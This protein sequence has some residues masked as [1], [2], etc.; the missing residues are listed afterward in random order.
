MTSLTQAFTRAPVRNRY[1]WGKLLDAEHLELEQRYHNEKR[2]LINRHAHGTGVLCGLSVE[3][4]DG[5]R[6]WIRPGVALDGRGREIVVTESF[7]L[8]HPDQPTDACGTPVGAPVRDAAVWICLAYHECDIEPVRAL[9]DSCDPRDACRPNAVRER[10][11]VLVNVGE[12]PVPESVLD[13]VRA[14][15]LQNAL[16]TAA[17]RGIP[18]ALGARSLS[19]NPIVARAQERLL[20]SRR[21]LCELWEAA[22]GPAA[23]DCV[24]L[25]LARIDGNGG[26]KLAPCGLRRQIPSNADL[27]D[28]FLLAAAQLETLVEELAEHQRWLRYETGDGQTATAGQEVG[29]PLAVI[30][31]GARDE[32]LDKAEVRFRVLGA[33]GLVGDPGVPSAAQHAVTTGPDGVAV[34]GWQLGAT[35]GLNLAEATFA[36]GRARITFNATAV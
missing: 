33:D 18:S 2:W 10:F 22:C 36:S 30:A 1:F 20:A 31:L 8:E 7:C 6:V 19:A 24:P 13:G 27:L 16:G 11:R 29:T 14:G 3:P 4:A 12:P 17:L 23:Q 15:R 5:T 21:R 34:A 35:P 9:V 26:V 25:A 32:P 28:G